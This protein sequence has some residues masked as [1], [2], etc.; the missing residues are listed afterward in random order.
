MGKDGVRNGIWG[1]AKAR[2]RVEAKAAATSKNRVSGP[3]RHG[4][5]AARGTSSIGALT[6]GDGSE[7]RIAG[8]ATRGRLVAFAEGL[9]LLPTARYACLLRREAQLT[10][11]VH[12]G[13]YCGAS[14]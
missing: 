1:G 4:R 8:L 12:T 3:R 2:I 6:S 11:A 10:H 9:P 14:G 7:G 5:G 13:F